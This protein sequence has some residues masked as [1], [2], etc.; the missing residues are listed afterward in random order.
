LSASGDDPAHLTGDHGR[1]VMLAV[2]PFAF[3]AIA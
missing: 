1:T 3:W 2:F